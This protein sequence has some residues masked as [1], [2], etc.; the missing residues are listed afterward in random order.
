MSGR[1]Y[2]SDSGSDSE[3]ENDKIRKDFSYYLNQHSS[4]YDLIRRARVERFDKP[5]CFCGNIAEYTEKNA[6]G[7]TINLCKEH[8][9]A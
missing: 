9:T 1:Y 2:F 5:K 3:Q 4:I 7:D 8:H 6:D